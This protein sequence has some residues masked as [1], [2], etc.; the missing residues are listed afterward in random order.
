M[1][2]KLCDSRLQTIFQ[3]QELE[4]SLKC[5]LLLQNDAK[6][7]YQKLIS[8]CCN[9]NLLFIDSSQYNHLQDWQPEKKTGKDSYFLLVFLLRLLACKSS[10]HRIS[11]PNSMWNQRETW[12]V[13]LVFKKRWTESQ[14]LPLATMERFR[15]GL[16]LYLLELETSRDQPICRCNFPHFCD[17]KPRLKL[18]GAYYYLHL[19]SVYDFSKQRLT[20]RP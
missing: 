17:Q 10:K 16:K 1:S 12:Q 19:K 18:P 5:Y 8:S 20:T 9:R 11:K 3:N 2:I 15:S 13:T 14:E 6:S 4:L 7:E